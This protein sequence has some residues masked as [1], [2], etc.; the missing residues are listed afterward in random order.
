MF[1]HR[2]N[3][4]R[5]NGHRANRNRANAGY[6]IIPFSIPFGIDKFER[7]GGKLFKKDKKKFGAKL[8]FTECK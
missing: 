1:T 8:V 2:A 6:H 4:T 3:G 7:N 5:A